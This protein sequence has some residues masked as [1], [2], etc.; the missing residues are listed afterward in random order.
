MSRYTDAPKACTDLA[1]SIINEHFSDLRSLSHSKIKLLLD[2]KKTLHNGKLVL[3]KCQKPNEIV[4]HFTIP[5][6][7]DA[8]G[9]QYI[10]SLDQIG[11]DTMQDAD[12]VRL[13]RHEL[14]H[15]GVMDDDNPKPSIEPHDLEDFCAEA[16]LNVD[17]P[18][19]ARKVAK[20]VLAIYG[21]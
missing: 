1:E 9:Y 20:K 19:W 13:L 4:K 16:I 8:N 10:I 11:W 6:T 17:D 3:G 2:S 12:K 18:D 7:K 21:S 15:V 5:E 14:R